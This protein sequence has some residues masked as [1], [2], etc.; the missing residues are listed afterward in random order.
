MDKQAFAPLRYFD[1]HAHVA[2][3]RFD[4]DRPS[5]LTRMAEAGVDRCL[6]CCDPTDEPH[7]V[8][9]TF[10]LARDNPHFACAIG[11]H[12][13]NAAWMDDRLLAEIERW[14]SL[15]GCMAV[16]EIGLDYHYDTSPRDRQREAFAQQLHRAYTLRKPAVLHIREAFLDAMDI[17]TAAYRA[18]QL[19]PCQMHCFSGSWETAKQCL[20]LGMMLS[21]SGSVTFKNAAKLWET[22]EK[23]PLERLLIETDCPYLS[24]EPV[25]GRRNEPAHVAH[26]AAHIARL[27]GISEEELASRT[28]EN[29]CRFFG[30]E[31][32]V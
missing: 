9:L 8:E 16:G 15:P 21:F 31:A 22:A 27:R 32:G 17:V 29:A 10:A 14:Q 2:D 12:P 23:A 18:G 28:Y 19:P 30:W 13:H 24:P 6:L 11:L 5:V 20:S 1:S 4:P 25:R 26:T 3:E 7:R